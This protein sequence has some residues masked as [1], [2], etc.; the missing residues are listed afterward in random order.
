VNEIGTFTRQAEPP[1]DQLVY[2]TFDDSSHRQGPG[3]C[4]AAWSDRKSRSWLCPVACAVSG[5]LILLVGPGWGQSSL[6]HAQELDQQAL[7]A[8]DRGQYAEA[9]RLAK[10]ALSSGEQILGATDL[11]VAHSLNT[12][13]LAYHYLARVQDALMSHERA[14]RIREQALGSAH[15]LVAESLTNLARARVSSGDFRGAQQLLERALQIQEQAAGTNRSATAVTLMHL[16]MVRGLAMDLSG[17][18]RDESRAVEMFERAPDAKPGDHSM[19]LTSLGTIIG[20]TGDFARARPLIER[21]L[22]MQE[23]TLGENHPLVARTLDSL[24][25]LASKMGAWNEALPVAERALRIREAAFGASHV[26]VAAS[27]NTLGRIHWYRREL[28]QAAQLF[29][30]AIGITEKAVGPK[31]PVV[32]ANLLDLGEVRR[33]MGDLR[34]A[35]TLLE[36][37]IQIQEQSLGATHPDLATSLT[38]LGSVAAQTNEVGRAISLLT[39]AVSIREQTLGPTHPDLALSLNDLAALHHAKGEL[40]KARPLYE[41]AR[42]I[43]LTMGQLNEDLDDATLAAVAKRGIAGL[44]LYLTLLGSLA[45]TAQESVRRSA[46]ADSFLIAEQARGWIVQSAVAKAMARRQAGS[47]EEQHDAQQVEELRRRRQTLRASLAATYRQSDDGERGRERRLVQQQLSQVQQDLDRL[48]KQLETKFPRYA[49]IALPKPVEAQA[50]QSMLRPGEALLSFYVLDDRVQIWLLKK[51][52]PIIYRETA[53]PRTTLATLVE[54]LRNSL[55]PLPST[56]LLPPVDVETAFE[57][58]RVLVEPVRPVVADVH[59]LIIVPDELLLPLPFGALLTDKGMESYVRL[60]SLSRN[61]RPVPFEDTALRQYASLP[62]LAK[63]YALSVLPTAGTLKL[64]RETPSRREDRSEPFIGFA[65][66]LFDGSGRERGSAMVASRGAKVDTDRLRQLNRLPGTRE[67]VLSMA[68]V[69]GVDLDTHV[70]LD[71]RATEREVKQLNASGRL[72]RA[73]V[74]AF[75]T[76]GLLAGDILGLSQPALALTVPDQPSDTDDGLLALDEV[77]QL[78]LPQT[79]LV[80]LSACNTAGGDGSGEALSGLARAFFFAGAKALLVSYWSVDDAATQAL[81]T[82]TFTRYGRDVRLPAAE[83]LRGGMQVLIARAETGGHAYF[84]HPYAWAGF[85]LVGEG[86]QR[87]PE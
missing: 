49:S 56:A 37:A 36:R 16:G 85:F 41:R 46:A 71:R 38:R 7:G 82:E 6:R 63:A 11:R 60:A 42:Q 72:G 73:K 86:S 34:Q 74:V 54:R 14:L 20:R 66:P 31:H 8:I 87:Q 53:V 4:Q 33:Q 19:A 80:V 62:W 70:Y 3:L 78:K 29:E 79:E 13:G 10:E 45:S 51:D 61:A 84:A 26:E 9:L 2:T 52:Q 69:F 83:A 55:V 32:A 48:V 76:H 39:R 44:R 12:L 81:M 59:A 67:E 65:D 40:D 35:R 24:A 64:L 1:P 43:Y 23:Q 17:A 18:I 28:A 27:L 21:A 22:R 50:I 5:L 77:L 68:R 15:P 47:V 30:Q 25:D 58:Y 57:L 75:S